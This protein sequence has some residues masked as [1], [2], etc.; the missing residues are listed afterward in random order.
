M[1]YGGPRSANNDFAAATPQDPFLTQ[2][3]RDTA[4]ATRVAGGAMHLLP[5]T[6]AQHDTSLAQTPSETGGQFGTMPY[7]GQSSTQ[8]QAAGMRQTAYVPNE[9]ENPFA[10]SALPMQTQAP[11]A[12][13]PFAATQ[14]SAGTQPP[15]AAFEQIHYEMPAQMATSDPFA[16]VQGG[17][18]MIAS[19]SSTP[20]P[21][22]GAIADGTDGW[23]PSISPA[24]SFSQAGEFVPPLQ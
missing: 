23:Q 1:P 9:D 15:G 19:P 12:S 3:S 8:P 20:L 13:Q 7:E 14:S 4:E 2:G 11:L 18:N 10:D 21:H 6:S 5:S 17:A 22:A 24:A 16:E